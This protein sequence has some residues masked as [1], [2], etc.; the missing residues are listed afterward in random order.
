MTTYYEEQVMLARQRKA[1]AAK[2]MAMDAPYA[3]R[4]AALNAQ[5]GENRGLTE[6]KPVEYDWSNVEYR[7]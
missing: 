3:F 2:L 1:K 7:R 6:A 5:G 4:L